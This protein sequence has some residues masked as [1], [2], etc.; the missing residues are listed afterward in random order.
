MD[1]VLENAPDVVD[2]GGV[3]VPLVALKVIPRSPSSSNATD[4]LG[5]DVDEGGGD[6]CGDPYDESKPERD[7]IR[8]GLGLG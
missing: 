2:L 6:A 1:D 7:D 4:V 3:T 5:E 8:L